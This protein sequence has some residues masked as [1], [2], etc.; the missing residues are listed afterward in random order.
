MAVDVLEAPTGP[1]E[2]EAGHS[3]LRSQL[4]DN[5]DYLWNKKEVEHL[6]FPSHNP[7]H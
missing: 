2:R 6:T 3:L 1:V 7:R 5:L 4:V